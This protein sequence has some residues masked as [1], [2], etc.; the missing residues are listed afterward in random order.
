MKQTYYAFLLGF[1]MFLNVSFTLNKVDN[2]YL[3]M[4]DIPIKTLLLS[5]KIELRVNGKVN[6]IDQ[7][8]SF[9]LVN[10]T[11]DTLLILIQSGEKL[12]LTDPNYHD[13]F[14]VKSGVIRLAPK[15]SKRNVGHV[16]YYES[17]SAI[18]NETKGE[19]TSEK[20]QKLAK[21]IDANDFPI[22][23]IQAAIWCITDNH[24]LSSITSEDKKNI[25]LL[26]RTV[27][28]IQK[29]ELPWYYFTSS[30]DTTEV[31]PVE[32]KNIIGN[33]E[34]YVAS[35][36]IITINIRNEHDEIMTTLI[37]ESSLGPGNHKFSI[38]TSVRTWPKGAYTV[39]VYEDYSK[40]IA[41]E[42]FELN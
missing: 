19:I 23:A 11:D 38:N 28:E 15:Q 12:D 41:R 1:V 3:P 34:F 14:I 30:K 32:H 13:L 8:L 40:V 21:V 25:Q 17:P 6:F 4:E 33:I 27:N 5:A 39:F 2:S 31:Y 24:P 42:T 9:D 22:Q 29:N 36:T 10:L 20:W 7:C 37:K 35:S 26:R 18:L 16:F